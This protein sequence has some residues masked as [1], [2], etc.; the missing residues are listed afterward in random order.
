MHE[1]ETPEIQRVIMWKFFLLN[2]LCYVLDPTTF[3]LNSPGLT[4]ATLQ[5]QGTAGG[6]P[7]LYGQL[8]TC[9]EKSYQ[10]NC[11]PLASFWAAYWQHPETSPSM[12]QPAA[13]Q[14][15]I[16][17]D[18]C[19][20]PPPP[21]LPQQRTN[22]NQKCS[23]HSSLS[24]SL[25]KTTITVTG[26]ISHSTLYLSKFLHSHISNHLQP[27][28]SSVLGLN[29]ISNC[30]LDT[31]N[32]PSHIPVNSASLLCFRQWIS[33]KIPHQEIVPALVGC[34]SQKFLFPHPHLAHTSVQGGID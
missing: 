22:S 26:P 18:L 10:P 8:L 1:E 3:L 4:T 32:Q 6:L 5:P 28:A 9:L 16:P 31:S 27:C 30:F 13:G 25:A 11:Q 29:H 12:C 23:S 14:S 2:V 24:P 19:S 17:S 20:S 15:T 33:L 21:P 34:S 7:V